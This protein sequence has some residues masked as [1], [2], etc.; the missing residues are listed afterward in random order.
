MRHRLL[1]LQRFVQHDIWKTH[2]SGDPERSDWRMQFVR[3]LSLAFEGLS[4]NQLLMRASGLSYASL[5]GLGPLVAI[6]VM[7]SGS[8]LRSDLETQIKEA[9][10]IVAPTLRDYVSV[11]ADPDAAD[12]PTELDIFIDQVVGGAEDILNQV[13]TEGGGIFRIVGFVL[14]I[15]VGINLLTTIE[16]TLNSIWGVTRGRDWSQRV[17]SYWTFLS[18]GTLLGIGSTA[19]FSASTLAGFT[20]FLPFGSTV[21]GFIIWLSPLLAATML[22]VFLTFSYQFFPNTT[23]RFKPALYG[24]ILVAVLLF[25]VNFLSIAYL[26][27]VIRMR[28]FFG[29]LAIFFVLMLGLYFFWF[30]ILLGA[31]V[32]YAIQNVNFLTHREVW[33]RISVRTQELVTLAAFLRIARRFEECKPPPSA[34]DLAES[35]RVPG[36]V[37]NKCIELLVDNGWVAAVRKVDDDG[38]EENFYRPAKPLAKYSLGRFRETFANHGNSAGVDF[39]ASDDP[40][41]TRYLERT[42]EPAEAPDHDPSLDQLLTDKPLAPDRVSTK[43]R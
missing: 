1:R 13:N 11:T 12:S 10:L 5:I 21:S 25:L 7:V 33:Q 14:L 41:L 29:S 15:W 20:D 8:F 3:V 22:I 36:N 17:V 39:V 32:T 18:L 38:M 26:G 6:A 28:S 42:S 40:L 34:G 4:K 43:A 30:I 37:L 35:L 16:T 9:L 24:A 27:W 31:Q 23:V 19:L 2:H